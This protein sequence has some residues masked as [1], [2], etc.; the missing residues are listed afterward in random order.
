LCIRYTWPAFSK[1]VHVFLP[2]TCISPSRIAISR[3]R[4]S[5]G[6][7]RDGI[8]CQRWSFFEPFPELAIDD[9]SAIAAGQRSEL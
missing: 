6:R 4:M 7:S 2:A 8:L 5:F 1:G 9:G 3:S